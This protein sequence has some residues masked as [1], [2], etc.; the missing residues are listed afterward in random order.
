MREFTPLDEFIKLFRRWWL[1]SLC[2]LLGALAAYIFHR[3]N[4]PLYEA[5]ATLMATIDLDTFPF[6]DVRM[7]LIQYNEDMAL[8]AV[9]GVLRSPEVTQA[10][11]TAAQSQSISLS[12]EELTRS[13]TIERKHAIWEVRF[14]STDPA[15]AQQ[16]V[17][18]WIQLGYESMLAWQSDGRIASFV[19]FEAP[20]PASL[21]E[22][23]I[24][25]ALNNLLLAGSMAGFFLG[26]L[27]SIATIKSPKIPAG[28]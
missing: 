8:A 5:T 17:N 21:P 11:F 4:P 3:S 10:L 13:S 2:I 15:V 20:T 25:Y 23:P 18:I 27:F 16:V 28:Q 19:I 6:Q 12:A 14:R 9:E 1:I 26:I 7:D 22:T 24:A